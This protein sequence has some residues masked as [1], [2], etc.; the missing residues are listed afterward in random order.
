MSASIT[1][2]E[3]R[4]TNTTTFAKRKKA[5]VFCGEDTFT[6]EMRRP[7]RGSKERRTRAEGDEPSQYFCRDCHAVQKRCVKRVSDK[8]EQFRKRVSLESATPD[9][10]HLGYNE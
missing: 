7:R 2:Q 6:R 4:D 3:M 5:L 9:D 1:F 8:N 10:D